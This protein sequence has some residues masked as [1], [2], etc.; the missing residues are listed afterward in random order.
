M[1]GLLQHEAKTDI[2]Q[3]VLLLKLRKD[4]DLL[5]FNVSISNVIPNQKTK[6]GRKKTDWNIDLSEPVVRSSPTTKSSTSIAPTKS[7]AKNRAATN[8]RAGKN[9]AGAAK[10]MTPAGKSTPAIDLSQTKKT[11]MAKNKNGAGKKK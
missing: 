1:Q 2:D 9:V 11:T 5:T 3:Q 7:T 6:Q 4:L 10:R 8:T